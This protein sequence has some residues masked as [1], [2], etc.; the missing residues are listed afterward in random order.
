MSNKKT[1]III[2]IV[3]I[4]LFIVAV[5]SA[6]YAYY[7]TTVQETGDPDSTKVGTADFNINFVDGAVMTIENMIPGDTFSKTFT[8]ENKGTATISYKVVMQEVR[9]EEFIRKEDITY[10]LYEYVVPKS[11][12]TA[13]TDF[14]ETEGTEEPVVEKALLASG[15]F[16]SV[17]NAIS[18][19]LSIEGGV[20]K[21]YILEVT[22]ENVIDVDQK[23]DMGKTISG[24]LFIEEV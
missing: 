24:K 20:T 21:G 14:S 3:S 13:E 18:E 8:L 12:A 22:Y 23:D 9:N 2:S 15:I 19:T 4:I 5:L 16:P 7:I 6:S 11:E 10:K 17:T 1:T